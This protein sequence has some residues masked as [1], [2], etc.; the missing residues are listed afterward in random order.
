MQYLGTQG[1]KPVIVTLVAACSVLPTTKYQQDVSFQKSSPYSCFIDY[2]SIRY[3]Q[4][5][6]KSSK[7]C[8]CERFLDRRKQFNLAY[9]QLPSIQHIDDR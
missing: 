1:Y 4:R 3:L 9:R 5:D 7:S 8:T 2:R 6:Y